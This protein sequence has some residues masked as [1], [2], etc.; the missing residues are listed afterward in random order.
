MEQMESII[1][2]YHQIILEIEDYAI[3]LL[4]ESGTIKD[5][6]KG[7]EKLKGYK[8]EE[9][10]GKNFHVFYTLEDCEKKL[11]EKLIESAI[12]NGKALDE[13]WRV[14]KD[15]SRF[16][17]SILITALHSQK[18]EV[19]GFSKITRDLTERKNLEDKL[20]QA[21]EDLV[22]YVQERTEKLTA[23]EDRFKFTLDNMLE[24][25]QVHDFNWRYIYVNDA[26]VRSS[27]YSKEQLLGFTLIEKY[28]GIETTPLYA[29]LKQVMDTRVAQHLETEFIFPDKSKAHFDLS[30]QPVPEGIFILS[31]DITQRKKAEEELNKSNR[32][33]AFI[34]AVNQGIVHIQDENE[35][36]TKAC[37]VAVS[38][39][40]F[41]MAWIG[42]LDEAGKL[43]M[44]SIGGDE[45]AT[46]NVRK[47]A[48][49]DYTSPL[50]QVTPTGKVLSTGTYAFSNDVMNDPGMAAWKPE[51]LLHGIKANMSLPIKKFGK[52]IGVFGFSSTV[53]DFFDAQE[54]NLL[55]EAVND[56]SFAIEN[57]EKAALHQLAEE[58]V[59]ESELNYRSL[60]EQATDAFYVADSTATKYLDINPA[61]CLMLDYTKEEFLKLSP[62]QLVFEEDIKTHALKVS[63]V[64]SGE[65]ITY[66]RRMKRKDG[67]AVEVEANGKKISDGRIVVIARDVSKRKKFE[68][69]QALLASIVNS[70]DD[71]IISKNLD[72]KITSW[73]R[74]AEKTF[75]YTSA[76]II[77]KNI[78]ILIP[79]Y[80]LNE[81][82]Q[83]MDKTR[84][85][86]YLDHYETERVRKDGKFIR[87]SHTISPIKDSDGNI[88]G[89]SKISHDIT[90]RIKNE[91]KEK[92]AVE[93]IHTNK[94]L[95][96]QNEAKEKRAA[97]LLIANKELAFQNEE[98][99]KRAAEL[100]IA[101][102]ELAFQS[103][104]KENR[105][106]ELILANKELVYQNE[107]KEKR[108]AELVIA[109]KELAFQSEEKESRALEL[110]IANKE[111]VFQNGEKEKRSAELILANEE[112][113]YQNAE[114]ENR[115][116]ELAVAN[117]ELAF[118][119]KEKEKR[120]SELVSANNE[121]VFQNEEK[122]KQ[123]LELI[124]VNDELESFSYSVSHD[125]RAPLRAVYGYAQM[126]QEDYG[127]KLDAEGIN[128]VNTI[129]RSAK[130]MG[131][132]IDDLLAFSRLGRKEL[133]VNE[134]SM[135]HM[136][137]EIC[138]EMKH[139]QPDRNIRFDVKELLPAKADNITIKQVW[140]NLISNAV[141]YSKLKVQAVVEIGS[142]IKDNEIIYYVKDNG[143]GFDMLYA[144]K[145]FGVFQRLHADNRFEGTGVGLAI[146]KRTITKH[147]GKV[148]AQGTVNEGATF[149]FSLPK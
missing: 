29:V 21:N 141:K 85:G 105:A 131:Q 43:N 66:R 69:Q 58:K 117:K 77:G 103:E 41:K 15:G 135:Q 7:A 6:N 94:E 97:E 82:K 145:L 88:I 50:L 123:A 19:I 149:Y 3:L 73:N 32:L 121:L 80:L 60:I 92:E 113:A 11:P 42:M 130:K 93:L 45:A 124:S 74:G 64:A 14:R 48:S 108:A 128:Q 127:S 53:K 107:E 28:P 126:L 49:Q 137:Q 129:M 72:G 17:G 140:V 4:D 5:W 91:E 115:A 87:V 67:T 147:H 133:Q 119:S 46:K 111:L 71:A 30:V 86:E 9:I 120:A 10:I 51:F 78:S 104:E 52:I 98:K 18:G 1:D 102:K 136:V 79:P 8:A 44:V 144:D 40:E 143:A 101:N 110:V 63:Q 20:K 33:Y 59:I 89:A 96:F 61:G 70:S 2:N 100:V 109:N 26:L 56:V 139:D 47:Y 13:G 35:L 68:E 83:I 84:A 12:L 23:S 90:E 106:L 142:E 65:I 95:V 122:E 36:L 24:G 55:V 148:W 54:I 27:S 112:L 22:K 118:Q 99:E 62:T 138:K 37:D 114:K 38:I 134:I 16:W 25:V 39:G 57:F 31:V 125:L 146:V 34:S 116:S 132:L 81:E 75:G 76:E